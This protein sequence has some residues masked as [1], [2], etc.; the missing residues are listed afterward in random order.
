MV[1]KKKQDQAVICDK[2]DRT[3]VYRLSYLASHDLAEILTE[4]PALKYVFA[5]STVFF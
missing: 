4:F 2:M 3:R 5:L 1:A